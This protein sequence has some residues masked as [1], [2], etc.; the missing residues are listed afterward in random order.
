MVLQAQVNEPKRS[1]EL[2]IIE[3]LSV[4]EEDAEGYEREPNDP[5]KDDGESIS[6]GVLLL[7]SC[8]ALQTH[9]HC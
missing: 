4:L 3:A 5:D 1:L 2:I 7:F 6:V 8:P 9:V